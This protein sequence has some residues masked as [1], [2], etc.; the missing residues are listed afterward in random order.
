M[1]LPPLLRRRL[2]WGPLAGVA[3][4]AGWWFAWMSPQASKLSVAHA[5]QT[6]DQ[7]TIAGLEARISQLH[8]VARKERQAKQLVR[9]FTRAVPP[10]PDAPVLVVQIYHLAT[11]QHLQLESITDNAVDP[12]GGYATIPLS[13]SVS[14]SRAGITRFVNGLYDLPRLVT[15]QQL[16]LSGPSAGNVVSATSGTNYQAT[17]TATAYTTSLTAGSTAGSTA[18]AAGTAATTGSG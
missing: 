12:A 13:L 17:I 15:V 10:R 11:A 4:L 18:G 1:K 16:Q 5:Q 2:F 7:M 14:G 8:S 6:T 3:L 9:L